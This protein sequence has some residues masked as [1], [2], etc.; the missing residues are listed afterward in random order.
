MQGLT[1]TDQSITLVTGS[2]VTIDYVVT[3]SDNTTTVITPGSGQ[4]NITT[5]TTTTIIAAPAASTYRAIKGV[6]ITNRHASSSQTVQLFKLV[7]AS[8][9]AIS[10][11]LSLLAGQ[12]A[13]LS[14]TGL[15]ILTASQ[16]FVASGKLL[17]AQNSLNLI[18]TDGT[19]QT[20]PTTNCVVARTDAAQT[21][22]GNQTFS[23]ITSNQGYIGQLRI[24]GNQIFENSTDADYSIAINY[25][26]YA[27][28]IT[29]FRDLN[30]YNG[31]NTLI[32]SF[33]G[34][35][36]FVGIGTNTPQ[37]QVHLSNNNSGTT[38][39]LAFENIDT[40]NNNASTLS[41]RTKTTGIGGA[42][43]VE[44]GAMSM[45]YTDHNHATRA[46]IF[47][48]STRDIG[49]IVNA[50]TFG[51]D[52]SL[53]VPGTIKTSKLAGQFRVIVDGTA[54]NDWGII[55]SGNNL[56]ISNWTANSINSLIIGNTTVSNS[57]TTGA[58]VVAGGGG[59]NGA[60]FAT[61]LTS[62]NTSSN[63]Y[64][65]IDSGNA[66]ESAILYKHLGTTRWK[67]GSDLNKQWFVEARDAS[68]V[69]ID[70]P[71][72]IANVSGG[73]IT[74]GGTT[75]RLVQHNGPLSVSGSCRITDATASTSTT[76][77]ALV[78]S[79]GVGIGGDVFCG[80]NINV[81]SGK[82]YK[83]NAT[84]VLGAQGAAVADATGAGDVV[85]QLNALLA[86]CRAHGIIAT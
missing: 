50:Y 38:T 23:T 54:A 32:A 28:S 77:G 62:S 12:S 72:S 60:V 63:A 1:A 82:V 36:G 74:L 26:G 75:Q 76:T 58:L 16:V 31:K 79:G 13:V 68:G 40:T 39:I 41:F 47:S 18:G 44:M 55:N 7:G 52:G 11:E 49:G 66:N 25:A 29:R 59:F 65:N 73:A 53:S 17:Q 67:N 71:I 81:A 35:T 6:M 10:Q 46:S 27:S 22:T 78:V 5:A 19:S 15:S 56:R 4:G 37:R 14:E 85:A 42:D 80:G 43:F 34:S 45:T 84:Q 86:R 70:Q 9:F 57:T 30:I 3:W 2:A 8:S 21:F 69:S 51:Q 24:V 33:V 64:I 83:V 48:V 61:S 20:F